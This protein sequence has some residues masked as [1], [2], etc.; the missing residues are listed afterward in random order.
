MPFPLPANVLPIES[1]AGEGPGV[2]IWHVGR[3][4]SSVLGRCL[5]QHPQ[6]QWENEIFNR[7]MPQRRGDQP[8]PPL[9]DAI[10][11]VQQRRQKP[12]QVVEVKFLACQ[13]PG[14]F[15]LS[16]LEL[17]DV[18]A[19][20]GFPYSVLLERGNTLR[21][22]VSHCRALQGQP[23]HLEATQAATQPEPMPLPLDGIR[24]GTEERSLLEWLQFMP[25]AYQELRQ[26][27]S[28]RGPLLE[29]LYERDLEANPLQGYDM[30]CR[31]L[32]LEQAPAVVS[33]Q[34]TNPYPLPL[35]VSNL[36]VVRDMIGDTD[37]AWMLE[38]S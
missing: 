6:L 18:L 10:A 12:I 19:E 14:L 3:C 7:W 11:T 29:L 23:Y 31:F 27:L 38:E 25:K 2:V 5:N 24:V 20:A 1:A 15:G 37:M 28:H 21:R 32:G 8:V 13:H 16:A 36:N 30:I 26:G 9:A 4:G 33:L 35:L 34:R 17:A 22:M